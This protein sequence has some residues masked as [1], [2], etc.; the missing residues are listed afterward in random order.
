MFGLMLLRS[1]TGMALAK[2]KAILPES[3]R[4]VSAVSM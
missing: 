2:G 4:D 3:R 1:I